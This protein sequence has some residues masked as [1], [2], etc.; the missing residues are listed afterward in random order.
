MTTKESKLLAKDTEEVMLTTIDNP[1]S[2]KTEYDNWRQWDVDKGYHTEQ[3]LARIMDVPVDVDMSDEVT[4]SLIAE[5]AMY[6]I[7]EHDMLNVYILV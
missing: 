7:V 4:L 1:F 2:P 3:Y 5:K 6:E